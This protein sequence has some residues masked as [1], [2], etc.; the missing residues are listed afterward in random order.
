MKKNERLS[1]IYNTSIL[2][3]IALML[4]GFVRFYQRYLETAVSTAV[5]EHA[6]ILSE[7]LWTYDLESIK[8]FVAAVILRD[9][10][11]SIR[12]FD[13]G[14]QVFYEFVKPP[15][16]G[17]DAA[18]KSLGFENVVI[19]AEKIKKD[20]NELG[21]VE[22]GWLNKTFYA[23]LTASFVAVL[24]Y[25][26]FLLY[27]RII[28]AKRLLESRIDALH[29]AVEQIKEQK[30]YI[31]QIFDIVPESLI[32]FDNNA[33]AITWNDSFTKLV[34]KWARALGRDVEVLR[35]S[36]LD[37]LRN[38]LRLRDEG[39]YVANFGG[40][41]SSLAFASS[42]VPESR[43]I[44]KV[45]SLRDVTEMA[46]MQRR[47]NQAEK[48]ESVGRLAAGIA[49]EINTPTQFVVTNLDFLAEAYRDLA[50]LISQISNCIDTADHTFNVSQL[51]GELLEMLEK[52]DWTFLEQE[53]PGA[54]DQSLEGL[55]RIQSIVGAM[56][57]FAHPAGETAEECDVNA[58]IETTV[59]VARN[60]WK[61]VAEM[62]LDLDPALPR[63]RCFL[64]QFNQVILLMI[65]NSVHALEEKVQAG[66]ESKGQIA[67]NS[68]ADE[69]FIEISIADN[70]IGMS[71]D[72]KKKIF[73]PFFTTKAVNKGTG[74]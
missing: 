69:K 16:Q 25:V 51:R 54:L 57:R 70:G 67:I 34:E 14:G 35:E 62:L 66:G 30:E 59:T 37:Q 11:Q 65:M 10:Y 43:I 45:V 40:N 42:A 48:L 41:L 18:F 74:Q 72:V 46:T 31:E 29:E 24:L 26:I 58:A 50:K 7:P 32:T 22:L 15:V 52:A 19:F 71:H 38:E 44:S 13:S 4:W 33:D 60:E 68:R 55:K 27:G 64:D 9:D 61:Y 5:V 23:N 17:I 3:L 36:F 53:I 49:H 47:L 39:E 2:L 20:G 8:G 12:I 1:I 21:K 73:E 6:R 56:K 63:V 28:K